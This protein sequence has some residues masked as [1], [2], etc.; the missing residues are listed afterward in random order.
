MR[1]FRRRITESETR[2]YASVNNCCL[3]AQHSYAPHCAS[4]LEISGQQALAATA[5]MPLSPCTCILVNTYTPQH[6]RAFSAAV[7]CHFSRPSTASFSVCRTVNP[8][9]SE[10]A[11][12]SMSFK[13]ERE[14]VSRTQ[15]R[16]RERRY[17]ADELVARILGAV[18]LPVTRLMRTRWIQK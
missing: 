1:R 10:P 17:H 18:T 4:D 6:R 14:R 7:N 9:A 5:P 13:E 3:A 2:N 12:P 15:Q 11:K 16:Y 8:C